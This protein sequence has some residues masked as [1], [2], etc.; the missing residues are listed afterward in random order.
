MLRGLVSLILRQRRQLLSVGIYLLRTHHLALTVKCVLLTVASCIFSV[1]YLAA[2]RCTQIA[3][4]IGVDE[5]VII[6]SADAFVGL[7]GTQ[8]LAVHLAANPFHCANWHVLGPHC[9]R[10]LFRIV[11]HRISAPNAKDFILTNPL[12][13]LGVSRLHS[14]D[15]GH[16]HDG[17]RQ[18]ARVQG[19]LLL[20]LLLGLRRLGVE[21]R[22]PVG[23]APV[24]LARLAALLS[25]QVMV[26]FV[27]IRPSLNLRH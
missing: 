15:V 25:H 19:L 13:V 20:L 16:L 7:L 3:A 14:K 12:I 6:P 26:V 22:I 24:G 23:A 10:T 18:E 27:E 2:L 17:A 9:D 21:D 1:L 5:V 11:L 8:A 4:E